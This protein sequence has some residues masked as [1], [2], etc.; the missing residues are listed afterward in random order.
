MTIESWARGRRR[1]WVIRS[2][3]ACR[4]SS[5]AAAL[6]V[7]VIDVDH[8]GAD[9]AVE[10]ACD[11]G[12]EAGSPGPFMCQRARAADRG[13]IRP[14]GRSLSRARPR[15]LGAREYGQRPAAALG[16]RPAAS[17]AGCSAGAAPRRSA[18]SGGAAGRTRRR[19][20]GAPRSAGAP[21]RPGTP[22]VSSGSD[23]R[24]GGAD[25]RQPRAPQARWC[26]SRRATRF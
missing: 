6:G 13:P 7:A 2:R 5:S 25:W 18:V 21:P 12:R 22:G 11:V 23:R 17:S 9:Y 15:R 20:D 1:Q 10:L 3:F 8:G 4:S 14:H 24:G 19:R 16:R 26:S